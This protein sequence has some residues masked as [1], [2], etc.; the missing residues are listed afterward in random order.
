MV[1]GWVVDGWW[2]VVVVVWWWYGGVAV[3]EQNIARVWGGM[4]LR[5]SVR[6]GRHELAINK[7]YLLQPRLQV[8]SVPEFGH[9]TDQKPT[10]QRTTSSNKY[11][12]TGT[13]IGSNVGGKRAGRTGAK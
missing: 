4:K 8:P 6:N 5:K 7:E 12:K 10:D 3:A 2:M 11:H 13:M 9:S 1:G